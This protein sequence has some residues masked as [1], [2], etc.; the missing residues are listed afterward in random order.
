MHRACL[1]TAVL[2][3]TAT[4]PGCQAPQPRPAPTTQPAA[5]TQPALDPMTS[6]NTLIEAP[7]GFLDQHIGSPEFPLPPYAKYLRGVKICLDP[8]HGGDAHKRGFKRGPTGVREAEMNLR[9][10]Q[11]LRELLIRCGADVKLTR[12][13][14]TDSSLTARADVA[15]TWGADL[16]VSIHHNAIGNKPKVNHTTVWYHNDVDYRPS[17]LDLARYL[18]GGLYDTLA[19]PELA[20]VPL[21]SDQLMYESGFGLLRAAKVT[22]ALCETSFFTNPAEEQ[23]LRTPEWNL[24]EAYG[25]FL[26]LARYAAA[27]LPKAAL[28]DPADGIIRLAPLHDEHESDEDEDKPD[29]TTAAQPHARIVLAAAADDR[30]RAELLPL[31]AGAVAEDQRDAEMEDFGET[32]EADVIP[33]V[34]QLDDGLRGRKSW[35]SERQMIVSSSLAVLLDGDDVPFTFTNESYQ[36][37]ALL[38]ADIDPGEHTVEVQFMNLFKNSIL[39]PRFKI[40]V[41]EVT[42]EGD[43]G[44]PSNP[45]APASPPP[46]TD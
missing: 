23:R 16:F 25:L 43:D 9:V 4:L 19:L 15:T 39:D 32:D 14:D 12:E 34:F 13:D 7:A 33:I 3:L 38:P 35:G 28:I 1:L 26:G 45:H 46:I 27:G 29:K 6:V 30:P 31:A 37:T 24:K 22:A 36:L 41:R 2:A 10:A 11:Y 44:S 5:A 8:G 20:D 42:E 18:C 21:K 17:N 40:D